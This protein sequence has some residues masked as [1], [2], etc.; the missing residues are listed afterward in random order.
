M[1]ATCPVVRAPKFFDSASSFPRR[2]SEIEPDHRWI[3][4]TRNQSTN[5][6]HKRLSI[7]AAIANFHFKLCCILFERSRFLA[8]APWPQMAGSRRLECGASR[9]LSRA[10]AGGVWLGDEWGLEER[11]RNPSTPS[12]RNRLTHL[13]TVFGVVLNWK[14]RRLC[15]ARPRPRFGPVPKR[16]LDEALGLAVCSGRVRLGADVLDA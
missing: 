14:R 11:S 12:A 16:G 9:G 13:A 3:P 2:R 7:A 8:S 4:S 10:V 5:S 15:S 6:I 1:S